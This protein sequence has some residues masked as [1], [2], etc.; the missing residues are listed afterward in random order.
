MYARIA[1][2]WVLPTLLLR[3]QAAAIGLIN[4]VGNLGG[5]TGAYLIGRLLTNGRSYS[6]ATVWLNLSYAL[7]AVITYL[8]GHG[9]RTAR[10]TES[11]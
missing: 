11:S 9:G 1:P 7:A 6:S 4:S 2:F 8:A 10:A 3:D 5:F